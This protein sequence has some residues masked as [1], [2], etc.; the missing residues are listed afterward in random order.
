M[1]KGIIMTDENTMRIDKWLKIAR[2][3]KQRVKAADAVE[4]A[5]VKVNGNRVK[6]SKLIK[7][8]DDLTVKKESKYTNYKILGISQRSISAELA[9]ELYQ[10]LDKPKESKESSELAQIIEKQNEKDQK[11]ARI[12]GKPNK[13]ER[14]I[15]NKYKYMSND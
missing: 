10:E 1:S 9:K 7:I 2:F 13:K 12:K 5:K 8:G 6:P 15:L 3:Y 11:E 14:R 4:N